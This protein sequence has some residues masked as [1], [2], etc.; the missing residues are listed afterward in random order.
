MRKNLVS[1]LVPVYNQEKHI[2]RCLRSLL[3][4]S[5]NQY[6]YEIII[7]NDASTDKTSYALELFEGDIIKVI[8]QDEK[9]GLPHALNMGIKKSEG[10]YIVRV[11]SDDY[12]NEHYLLFLSAFLDMNEYM[13]AV[14]CDYIIVDD[15]EKVL[16][17]KN[18]TEEPI[19]CGIMFRR[20]QIVKLGMYDTSM[21]A[22]ED[23]DMFIRF[24]EKHSI[25]RIELPLYRYRKHNRGIT[26]NKELMKIYREK[27]E[28]K[29]KGKI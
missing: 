18:F 6:Y 27:L 5:L 23:K 7:I 8:N 28:K 10:K 26:G 19:G 15:K 2:G 22:H 29:N 16:G 3:H 1:V 12:V 9:K 24:T 14:A 4:Q 20:E 25:H 21:K 11:D 17:I 13:D